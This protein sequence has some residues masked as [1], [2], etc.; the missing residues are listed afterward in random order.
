MI[1]KLLM[2]SSNCVNQ[3]MANS[4]A[5]RSIN[6]GDR[7]RPQIYKYQYLQLERQEMI[8]NISIYLNVRK[9]LTWFSFC[10][11]VLVLYKR[12]FEWPNYTER[13]SNLYTIVRRNAPKRLAQRFELIG[14]GLPPFEPDE[15]LPPSALPLKGAT[16]VGE[17]PARL[18]SCDCEPVALGPAAAPNGPPPCGD[19]EPCGCRIGALKLAAAWYCSVY[20]IGCILK[21]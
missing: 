2:T 12:F 6:T 8:H 17:P 13:F 7:N 19:W 10:S 4:N 9:V 1:D 3:W 20:A 11:R 18:A 14:L 21:P 15:P 16:R 5:K